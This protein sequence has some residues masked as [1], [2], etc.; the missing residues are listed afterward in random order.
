MSLEDKQMSYDEKTIYENRAS[1]RNDCKNTTDCTD[2]ECCPEELIFAMRDKYHEFSLGL[3]TILECL[4]IAE[5]EGY[6]PELPIAW[7]CKLRQ[8][9]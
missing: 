6:V 8:D 1:L 2:Y 5:S 9:G 7:W 4:Q 3:T